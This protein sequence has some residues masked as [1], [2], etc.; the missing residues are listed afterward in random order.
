MVKALYYFVLFFPLWVAQVQFLP[1]FESWV[2]KS[3]WIVFHSWI[4]V[5]A[6]SCG[7]WKT[8][9]GNEEMKENEGNKEK[10]IALV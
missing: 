6:V 9:M 4:F 5:R 10:N 7:V 2:T 1:C 8:G 3:D